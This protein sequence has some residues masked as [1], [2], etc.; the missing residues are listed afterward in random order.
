ME[1]STPGHPNVHQAL[2][3]LPLETERLRLRELT[4]ADAPFALELVNDPS[5][6]R[7]IGD[8]GI[9]TLDDAR[10]YLREGPMASYAQFGLG[11]FLTE[12]PES[13]IPIGLC[14]LLRRPTLDAPDI[15]F[16]FLP[17]FWGKGYAYEAAKAV[18][19]WSEETH[20]FPL[21]L[22]ITLEENR[23]SIRLLEKLGL[24]FEKPVRQPG[25]E[26]ELRLYARRWPDRI[27]K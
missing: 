17:R 15:G 4:L 27:E 11:L 8:R 24:R 6:I 14:G 22:A 20:A 9:H 3:H 13:G 5:W 18:I 23:S 7:F 10:R 21:V 16:A 2:E 1:N 25:D 19:D 26:E 12:L